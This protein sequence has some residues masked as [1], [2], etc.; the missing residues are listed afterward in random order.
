VPST[1]A[2]VERAFRRREQLLDLQHSL[3]RHRPVERRQPFGEP[4][5]EI[6]VWPSCNPVQR[7][8][9]GEKGCGEITLRP[10]DGSRE[11]EAVALRGELAGTPLREPGEEIRSRLA[12]KLEVRSAANADQ[13]EVGERPLERSS[14]EEDRR[15]DETRQRSD[16]RCEPKCERQ[17]PNCCNRKSG[18]DRTRQ[19][20]PVAT[21]NARVEVRKVHVIDAR[22]VRLTAA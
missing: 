3:R 10:G 20:E 13:L 7:R 8:G 4:E 15:E 14:G 11:R 17:Q 19:V 18:S 1:L 5:E 21:I 6:G 22:W 16:D 2:R 12:P 9:A